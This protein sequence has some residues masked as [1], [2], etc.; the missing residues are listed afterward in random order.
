MMR[1]R[2]FKMIWYPCGNHTQLFDLVC[3][4][5]EVNELGG[6]PAYADVVAGLKERLRS[7]MYGSD[8][9]WLD[10]DEVVGEP[11]ADFIRVRTGA[12]HSPAATNG[13]FRRS[14][15]KVTWSFSLK[16][17]HP[18]THDSV[19]RPPV[20][21]LTG[22]DRSAQVPPPSMFAHSLDQ[23]DRAVIFPCTPLESTGFGGIP[24]S[25]DFGQEFRRRV[26]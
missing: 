15:R 12:F 19:S 3:D 6:D 24:V 25:G 22:G 8:E 26:A 16:L 17:H 13:R 2:R 14:T 18:M 5:E 21:C 20:D 10:G 7:E 4:P 9:K 11:G 23:A 1:D